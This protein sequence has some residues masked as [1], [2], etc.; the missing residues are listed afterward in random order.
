MQR[1]G[2]FTLIEVII[3]MTL[4]ALIMGM[5]GGALQLGAKS[6]DSGERL[7]SRLDDMRLVSRFIKRQLGQAVAAVRQPDEP[8]PGRGE[9]S[10]ASPTLAFVGA[11]DHLYFIGPKPAQLG[12]DGLYHLQLQLTEADGVSQLQ[13]HYALFRAD[14]PMPEADEDNT[15]VLVEEVD[16]LE[17]AYFGVKEAAIT[18]TLPDPS[19]PGEW[20]DEWEPTQKNLPALVRLRLTVKGQVWPDCVVALPRT[21]SN[22]ELR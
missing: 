4:L 2:G 16:A 9:D 1:Q 18:A 6:S 20:W 3:A 10:S 17:F 5:V 8:Q 11:K 14:Q 21:A 13:L 15:A 19:Q 12:L 22:T 7:A